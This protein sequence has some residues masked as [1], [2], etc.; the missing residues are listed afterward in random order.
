[1]IVLVSLIVLLR[2][3]LVLTMFWGSQGLSAEHNIRYIIMWMC[4]GPMISEDVWPLQSI[5]SE[6]V[7]R[8]YNK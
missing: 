6:D 8:S 4:V 1:M 3:L 7:C 5:I 2:E